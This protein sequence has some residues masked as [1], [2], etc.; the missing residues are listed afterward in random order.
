MTGW[1]NDGPQERAVAGL[2]VPPSALKR[3]ASMFKQPGID[4]RTHLFRYNPF[5][6]DTPSNGMALKPTHVMTSVGLLMRLY[7]GWKR[8]LP[9]MQAGTDYLLNYL[10]DPGTPQATKRD[11][12]IG[13]MR[14]QVLF[15]MGGERWKS[16]MKNCGH[17]YSTLRFLRENWLA[18]G[19]RTYLVRTLGTLRVVDLCDHTQFAVIG[20]PLPPPATLRK[21]L[22]V[23]MLGKRSDRQC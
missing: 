22:P 21:Q 15:H 13:T 12:F 1:F 4:G 10:P 11:T 8:D 2:D 9:E 6:P 5:A 19:T 7:L 18:V 16:G 17:C 14:T 20:S 23:S 3:C